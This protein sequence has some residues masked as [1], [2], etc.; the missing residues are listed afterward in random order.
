MGGR[1]YGHFD[2]AEAIR[3]AEG[4][5]YAKQTRFAKLGYPSFLFL[6]DFED[7]SRQNYWGCY[8]DTTDTIVIDIT[9][10]MNDPIEAVT[11]TIVHEMCHMY[12]DRYHP[13]ATHAHG[14]EFIELMKEMGIEYDNSYVNPYADKIMERPQNWSLLLKLATIPV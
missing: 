12:I 2:K 3:I 5:A 14:K 6:V 4:I 8:Y 10:F 13:E 7:L 11:D 1:E 9:H